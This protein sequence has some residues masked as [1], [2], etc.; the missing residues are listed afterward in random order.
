MA[1][2]KMQQKKRNNVIMRYFFRIA[3]WNVAL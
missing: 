2:L 3:L 1:N